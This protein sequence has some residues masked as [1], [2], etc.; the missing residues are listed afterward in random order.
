MILSVKEVE[1][2]IGCKERTALSHMKA[3]RK[4]YNTRYVTKW[5]LADWLNIDSVALEISYLYRV[6][7]DV[8]AATELT[9]I[10]EGLRKRGLLSG[11]ALDL[12]VILT[13][14]RNM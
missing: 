7:K 6:K 9:A 13:A 1:A 14:L 3:I 12:E 8:K 11:P 4:K 2:L 5:H 10:R